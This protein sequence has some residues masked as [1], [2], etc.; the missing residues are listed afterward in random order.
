MMCKLPMN[1]N[2]FDVYEAKYIIYSVML[3]YNI[4]GE[5][6]KTHRICHYRRSN[7]I[8]ARLL[9]NLSAPII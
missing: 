4:L 6:I 3:G 8:F 5:T 1:K 7:H 2:C 9:T